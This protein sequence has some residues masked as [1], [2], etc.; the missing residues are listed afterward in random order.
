M[1]KTLTLCAIVLYATLTLTAQPPQ[2]FKYKAIAKND[3]GLPLMNKNISLRFTIYQ[4]SENGI[5]VYIEVHQTTTNIL[6]LVDVNIGQGTPQ[7]GTFSNIDWG[8]S[9]FYLKTEIDPRGGNNFRIED[10]THQLLSVPYALYAGAV[11]NN[12]DDDADP[13]NE[14]ISSVFLNGTFL[15]ITEGGILTIID[16]SGLQDGTE[17]AD[18]DPANEL[19]DIS[20]SGTNLSISEGSTVDLSVIQ[21][22]NDPDTDDQTLSVS[23]HELTISEGNTITL[24][25]DVNDADADSQNEIQDLQLSGNL[26]TI[27]KNGTA[28]V[29]DL[30]VFLDDTDTHLTETEVDAMVDNNGYLT[31]VAWTNIPDVPADLADG[32]DNTQLTEVEVDAMV[33]NNGYLTVEVDGDPANELQNLSLSG[34]QLTLSNDDT[35]VDLSPFMDDTDTHLTEA[36]VDAMVNNNG[37]LTTEADGDVNNEIQDISIDGH[38]LTISEGS[39]VQIP[40][41]VNDAD[42]D[43]MNELQDLSLKFNILSLSKNGRP[44]QI[45][46]TPYLDNTD[47]QSLSIDGHQLTIFNGN[48]IQLPDSVIDDDADPVNEIQQ[49]VLAGH[50]LSLTNGNIIQLPDSADDADADPANELITNVALNGTS[51]EITDAGGIKAVDIGGISGGSSQSLS[52]VLT[53]GNDAGGMNIANLADPINDQDAVTKAYLIAILDAINI[54]TTNFSGFITDIDGNAYATITIGDQTWMQKNLKTTKYNDNTAI[55]LVTDVY[56]WHDLTTPGYCWYKNN[57]ARYGTTYGALYNWYTVETG[58]L[59]PTDWHVP[60]DEEW[61]TMENYLIANGY[62]WDGS[63]SEDRIAKSLAA[64]TNWELSSTTGAVGNTDYS[65]IRNITGFTALPGGYR[66]CYGAYCFIGNFS[67]WWSSTDYDGSSAYRRFMISKDATAFDADT[68]EINCGFSVRCIK[69]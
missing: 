9:D 51:L 25:D 21:D 50:Q 19:Q 26:L 68:Y 39:T 38:M 65:I 55:P 43:P 13:Q 37:Y 23:G 60:T 18:A 61:T 62:N 59:C 20:L 10:G 30:S 58:N 6:G 15:E 5:P 49:L 16:L 32:D 28:T 57:E 11:L 47:E 45:D 48:T 56:E 63:T 35:P 14:L 22:G 44:D 54:F 17:D 69:D 27:T 1:K 29:I 46:L 52:S 33:A 3:W 2:A 12:D 7:L 66:N 34:N 8:A 41:S 24:P 40:D 67:S 42:H 31:G 36:E 53:L 64:A 4:G